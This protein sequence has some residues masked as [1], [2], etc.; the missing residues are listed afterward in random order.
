MKKR[1]VLAGLAIILIIFYYMAGPGCP[2][3]AFLGI[4]CP[5]CGMTRAYLQLLKGDVRGA[6]SYHPAFWIVPVAGGLLLFR[7]KFPK[8]VFQVGMVM[9][10]F[11]FFAVYFYRISCH[12]PVLICDF[13]QGYIYKIWR[14]LFVRG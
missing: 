3:K 9:V 2:Q 12:D 13:R 4:S 5:G 8:V 7:G 6:F 14:V 1:Y 10:A 11:V